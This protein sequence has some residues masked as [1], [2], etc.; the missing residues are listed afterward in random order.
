VIRIG[1]QVPMAGGALCALEYALGT[2]CETMQIF[3]KSPRRWAGP[4]LDSAAAETFRE[5]CAQARM[6]PVF[7]HAGYLIN[8][9]SDDAFL[10][11]RSSAALA[12]ELVRGAELGVSG[13]VVH[14]GRRFS[15]DDEECVDRVA[16]CVLHAREMAGESAARLLLE[17]SAGAGRQFGVDAAQMSGAL[18]AVRAAGVEAALCLDTCHA[19]AAGIDLRTAGAWSRVIGD[20][21]AA[22][23]PGAVAL[24]HANDCKG[25]LGSHKDRHEWIGQGQLGSAAF[26]A[27]FR[28]PRLEA[29]CV[30]VE[31]PGDGPDKDTQ[32]V[33]RLKALRDDGAAN[34]APTPAH[35]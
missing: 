6:G 34:G 4:P 18:N 26:G 23:G 19:F 25:E 32:N 9:G 5:A 33:S 27:L 22:C 7:S 30:V 17:N 29:A 21:S 16:R 14:L 31:M 1:A 13:V 11:E 2:G 28:E 3:A 24:V 12:D 15:D 20:L 8:M 10:W 35:A